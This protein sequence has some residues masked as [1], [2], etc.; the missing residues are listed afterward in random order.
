MS[1]Q[2]YWDG[3]LE[4]AIEEGGPGRIIGLGKIELAYFAYVPGITGDGRRK[5]IFAPASMSKGERDK[6]RALA[7]A[8]AGENGGDTKSVRWCAVTT[9]YKDETYSGS[10]PATWDYDR[11]ETVPLW[12][13]HQD[14]PSAGKLVMDTVK[15]LGV[16]ANETF[17]ARFGWK[18]DPYKAS[19][20]EDGK[21]D[22]DKDGNARFPQV[23]VVTELF[24]SK[25]AALEAIQAGAQSAAVESPWAD[26]PG[27]DWDNT[28]WDTIAEDIKMAL[29]EDDL[30]KVAQDEFGV[31]ETW[32][33]RALATGGM[34]A[35]EIKKVCGVKMGVVKA[36][37]KTTA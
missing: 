27:S 13:L 23:C 35:R 5:C 14:G 16:P 32:I 1:E 11:L 22:T 30:A 29:A 19:L 7:H 36:A 25:A 17:Y 9:V 24:E 18:N 15:G 8:F 3:A 21:T 10:D 2:N 34:N 37:L 4:G 12:T 20:G 26:W 31:D 28:D 33:I 6:A